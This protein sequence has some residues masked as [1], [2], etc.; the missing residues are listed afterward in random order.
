M[1]QTRLNDFSFHYDQQTPKL[2]IFQGQTSTT[3][4]CGTEFLFFGGVGG[5]FQQIITELFSFGRKD[6]ISE[7]NLAL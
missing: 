6:L 7:G 1:V 5:L 4:G 3:W 2:L